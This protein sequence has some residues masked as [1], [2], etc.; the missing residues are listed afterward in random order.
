MFFW[1]ALI[2]LV[3]SILSIK[4]LLRFLS[5]AGFTAKNFEGKKIPIGTG[6]LWGWVFL[7]SMAVM[8]LAGNNF[9]GDVSLAMGELNVIGILLAGSLLLGFIDDRGSTEE[10]GFR[11]HLKAF[12]SGK[13]T[14]GFIKAAGGLILAVVVASS[15]TSSVYMLVINAI[16]IVLAMNAVNLLDLRPGRALA[17]YLVLSIVLMGSAL[18]L[19]SN[20]SLAWHFWGIF[21]APALALLPSDLR[22]ESMLGDTGSNAMGAILGYMAA[23]TFGSVVKVAI[24]IALLVFNV[25]ADRISLTGLLEKRKTV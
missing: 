5:D 21:L 18:T 15:V 9:I 12:L 17:S 22:G 11:G 2:S 14:T 10:R 8:V 7:L 16:V 20:L 6:L 23:V 24:I 13:I 1:I 25:T 19:T 4:P 3:I